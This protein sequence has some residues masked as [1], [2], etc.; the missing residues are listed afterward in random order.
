M[1][2]SLIPGIKVLAQA[3]ISM[4]THW[5]NRAN[6]NPASIART[7]YIY[8]FTNVR[9]QWFGVEGAPKVFNIQASQYIHNLRS[10]F[11]LSLVSDKI[12]ATQALNPMIT[13][14]FRI[15]NNRNWSFSM[16]LS[17]GV[18]I[19]SVD[20]SLY[21]AVTTVDPSIQY[22]A[23]KVIK[24]DA[25]VGFEFQSTHFVFSISSTHLFSVYKADSLY[26]NTNH[27]YGSV[28]YINSNPDFCNYHIGLQV[29]NRHNLTV[30]EGNAGIRFKNLTGLASGPL[31]IFDLGFSY[32]SSGQMTLLFGINISPNLRV[33]Y[34]YQQT[35]STTSYQNGTHEMMLEFRIPSI[36]ASTRR[37]CVSLGDWY[38]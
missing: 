27:Q 20:G 16:G 37:Q 24:P 28:V 38:H 7:D 8:L 26:L 6:Y 15:A 3:D 30:L 25:N 33:G 10:A 12:G 34:A 9:Q 21:D 19:R 5:Y 23:E 31:E 17:S 32:R 2:V 18:F 1:F 14:A 29:V 22:Y 4:A 36:N 11:G 35:L 13:Y